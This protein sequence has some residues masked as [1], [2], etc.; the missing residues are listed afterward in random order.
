MRIQARQTA[1]FSLIELAVVLVFFAIFTVFGLTRFQPAETTLPAQADRLARDIRHMQTLALAQ[2]QGLQLA[3]SGT[4]YQVCLGTTATCNAGAAIVDPA[5]GQ[6]FVVALENGVSVSATTLA[7]DSLGRPVTG[8]SLS[9]ADTAF[10]LT[11]GIE[12]STVTVSRLTGFV[13][14]TY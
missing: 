11:G 7:M 13:T 4:A 6:P 1:G 8:G 10:T 3:A 2:G 9:A 14:I 12:S 5:N